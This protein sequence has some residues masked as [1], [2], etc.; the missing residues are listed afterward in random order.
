LLR[1]KSL[2]FAPVKANDEKASRTRDD[3]FYKTN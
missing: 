1:A 2:P 3:L